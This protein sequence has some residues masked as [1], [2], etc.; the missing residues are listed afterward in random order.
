MSNDRAIVIKGNKQALPALYHK[1]TDKGIELTPE[2]VSKIALGLSKGLA[3]EDSCQLLGIPVSIFNEWYGIGQAL[4]EGRSHSGI[5]DLLPRQVNEDLETY[6]SRE[7]VW[8][9]KCDLFTMCYTLP[10]QEKSK[11][12]G[13]MV[14]IIVEFANSGHPDAYKA[15]RELLRMADAPYGQ[16]TR[17]QIEHKHEISGEVT[18]KHLD[19]VQ[20]LISGLN[21]ISGTAEGAGDIIDGEILDVSEA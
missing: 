19:Q 18:H 17:A 12:N 7:A 3:V 9:E 5:P 13:D 20:T 14:S 8:V 6:I 1:K 4:L 21:S 2:V 11:F 15:A 10:N 16:K